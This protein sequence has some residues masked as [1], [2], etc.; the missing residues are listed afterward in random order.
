MCEGS[1]HAA[2]DIDA[3]FGVEVIPANMF[4]SRRRSAKSRCDVAKRRE[5]EQGGR[6]GRTKG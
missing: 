3:L 2:G 4:E 6:G 1:Q 5:R